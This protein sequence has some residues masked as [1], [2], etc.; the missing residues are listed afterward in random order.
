MAKSAK[1][2]EEAEDEADKFVSLVQ[3]EIEKLLR[4]PLEPKEKN[5]VIANAIRFLAVRNRSGGDDGSWWGG[6]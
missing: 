2:P 6:D 5:A 1:K 3:Q 4:E